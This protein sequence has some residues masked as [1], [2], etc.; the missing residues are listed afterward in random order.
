MSK[1]NHTDIKV[2]M[3]LLTIL[4]SMQSLTKC[5]KIKGAVASAAL[6]NEQHDACYCSF[7]I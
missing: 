4:H 2:Y 6:T 1:Y 3:C 7:C 5:P